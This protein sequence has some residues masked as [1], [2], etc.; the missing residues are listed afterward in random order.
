MDEVKLLNRTDTKY[1]LSFEQ[2]IDLLPKLLPYY[3]CLEINGVRKSSYET[4]YFDTSDKKFYLDH[5]NKK[6]NRHKVRIRKYIESNLCFLEIKH[7]IKGRTDKSRIKIDDFTISFNSEEKTFVNS[8][9]NE[10]DV[11]LFPSLWNSFSRITLV[12]KTDKE[13]LTFDVDLRFKTLENEIWNENHFVVAEVKQENINRASAFM[14]ISKQYQFR[15]LSMSKYC[16]GCSMLFN[17]L[18]HNNFKPKILAIKKLK[19]TA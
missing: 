7:K 12:N 1:L 16:L 2:F 14:K 8:K 17:S 19:Y 6:P 10:L 5:H 11:E 4:L 9:L 15:P 18:K 3:S 13:R